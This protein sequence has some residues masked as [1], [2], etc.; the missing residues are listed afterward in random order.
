MR[1]RDRRRDEAFAWQVFDQ[2]TYG[3]LSMRDGDGGYGVP[4]SPARI[5]EK[6]YFHCAMAGKKLECLS[7][8]PR[9]SL[10]VAEAGET[11]YF[12]ICYRSAI[13]SGTVFMVTDEAEKRDALAAITQRYC[14]QWM[15][16]LD[17]YLAGHLAGTCVFRL[18]IEEATGKERRKE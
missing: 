17:S 1:R 4:V 7:R 16:Q 9:V 8:W 3:T 10:A 14:P 13:F 2:A 6:V 5:G 12:S 18:D 15:A 11:D